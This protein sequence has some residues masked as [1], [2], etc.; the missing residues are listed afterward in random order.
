MFFDKYHTSLHQSFSCSLQVTGSNDFTLKLWDAK[1]GTQKYEFLGNTSAVNDVAYKVLTS[2]SFPLLNILF[3]FLY[4]PLHP[5]LR[6]S[7]LALFVCSFFLVF[8]LS[9]FCSFGL[10]VFDFAFFLFL[11]LS[12]SHF[13]RRIDLFNFFHSPYSYLFP[14]F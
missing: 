13:L 2:L 8:F 9:F 5:L 11:I 14:S 3:L 12:F 7:V 10:I 4:H 1:T 6:L